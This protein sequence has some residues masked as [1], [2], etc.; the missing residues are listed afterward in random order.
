MY[1]CFYMALIRKKAPPTP[2]QLTICHYFKKVI[3]KT[4]NQT[5]YQAEYEIGALIETLLAFIQVASKVITDA[6]RI[7]TC[8]LIVF[9][10][11]IIK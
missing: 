8:Q 11:Q 9:L 3:L 2:Q 10:Q 7:K 1:V 4:P 6:D 5:I